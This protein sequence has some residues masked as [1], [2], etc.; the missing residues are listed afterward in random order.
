MG[1]DLRCVKILF[2]V[3]ILFKVPRNVAAIARQPIGACLTQ[4]KETDSREEF[5]QWKLRSTPRKVKA[6]RPLKVSTFQYF[7]IIL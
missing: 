2:C 7:V 4:A 1:E 6:A 3:N 5:V